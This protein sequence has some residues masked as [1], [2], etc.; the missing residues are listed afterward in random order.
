MNPAMIPCPRIIRNF[1]SLHRGEKPDIIRLKGMRAI[2]HND[3]LIFNFPYSDWNRLEMDMNVFYAKR[4][5][6]IPGDTFCIENGIYKV[7]NCPDTLGN[8]EAQYR[9]SQM[10][11]EDIRPEI[12]NCFPYDDAYRWNVKSLCP[13]YIPRKGD[14]LSISLQ[15]VKLYRNLIRYETGGELSLQND[16]VYLNSEPLQTYIFQQ[17]YYFMAGDQIFDS[18][19]SRYWGLLPED[20][21]VGKAAIIWKSEDKQ[22][23]KRRWERCLKTI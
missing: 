19:D 4:C 3:V 23:G 8:Y 14:T 10:K 16:T 12:F 22:T 9:F 18:R 1:F 2:R 21:I 13:L 15:N 20:H 5:V 7:R 11:A 17:N 6:A